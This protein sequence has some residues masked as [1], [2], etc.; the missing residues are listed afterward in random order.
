[1]HTLNIKK[2]Q[3]LDLLKQIFIWEGRVHQRIESLVEELE[4]RDYAKLE[5]VY[6][7]V[8]KAHGEQRKFFGRMA[9]KDPIFHK[10]LHRK[11]QK[12]Y[13][14]ASNK[15]TLEEQSGADSLLQFDD[16]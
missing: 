7:S 16:V 10:K 3:I 1:M 2:S 9:Q 15:V 11:L 4:E 14:E 13:E 6:A 12:A 5:R 8:Q